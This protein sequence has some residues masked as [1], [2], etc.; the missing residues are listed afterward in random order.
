MFE[1][2]FK[3]GTIL[4][5]FTLHVKKLV[6]RTFEHVPPPCKVLNFLIDL[7]KIHPLCKAS[8]QSH[9]KTRL[10]LQVSLGLKTRIK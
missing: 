1:D 7:L 8:K 6:S 4:S 10:V 5:H 3:A 9:L 2:T